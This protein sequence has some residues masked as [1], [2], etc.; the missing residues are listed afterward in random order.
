MRKLSLF[1]SL[2]ILDLMATTFSPV[3]IRDQL[4]GA[5]GVVQGEVVAVSSE[6]D[7]ELG[8]ISKVFLKADRWIGV[9]V[10]D[11]HVELYFPGGE[12]GDEGSLVHGAPKFKQGEKVIVLTNPHNGRSWV[13]SLGLGKFTI[14][15]VGHTKVAV[16]Q[17]FPN[18]PDVG[19]M[20][21]KSFLS[22]AREL[23]GEK[24]KERFKDK[25]E[26]EHVRSTT[27]SSHEAQGRSIASIGQ[28][29]D[30]KS[31]EKPSP[32][33]LVLLLGALGVG[34]RLSWGKSRR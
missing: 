28:A 33:W 25:Y 21:L 23:K 16:N 3:T 12:L 27:S 8:I 13:Q 6:R 29:G 31:G 34:V 7:E 2:F 4:K 11:N 30:G 14:K 26:R 9:D 32:L 5:E 17:I 22:M 10:V 15:K 24:F 19:Q 1:A 20:R 18:M